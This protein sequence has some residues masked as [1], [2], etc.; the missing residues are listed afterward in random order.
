MSHL[1]KP[2]TLARLNDLVLGSFSNLKPSETLDHLL[3]QYS[4][5][6]VIPFLRLRAR[7]QHRAGLRANA[8]SGSADGFSKLESLLSDSRTL[9]RIWGLLPIFQ[10]LISLERNPPA[11]RNLLTIERLQGWSMLG[12]YPLEHLYYLR[13]HKIIPESIPSPTT[14][15]AEKKKR[16]PL[17]VNGMALW[18]TRFWAAYIFLHFAHLWEDL[19]L[20]KQRHAS[21]KK[22]KSTLTKEEKSEMAQ[23]WDAFW[24]EVVIN[25]GYLPLTVHWSLEKG[26][27]SNDVWVGVFG[28]VA[29]VASFRT[30]WKATSLPPP[31]EKKE[32]ETD[33]AENVKAY[34]VST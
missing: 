25:L 11:T 16:I 10:W 32:S 26:L 33:S 34:D 29:A 27:F 2:L 28:L 22:A 12:Y 1:A 21:I 7:L 20:L 30:G 15:F 8:V 23:R 17:D 14:I 13:M 31:P 6:L 19:K 3:I 4:L 5:K 9:W 18:S 24:S